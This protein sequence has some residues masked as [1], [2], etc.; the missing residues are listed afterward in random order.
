MRKKV[1]FNLSPTIHVMYTWNYAYK[2][3]R[4]SDWEMIA[5]DR[6]RFKNRIKKLSIII[7]PILEQGHRISIYEKR[8][9]NLSNFNNK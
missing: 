9:A 8:F 5:R 1:T 6:E 7:L 3:A 4:K 2:A